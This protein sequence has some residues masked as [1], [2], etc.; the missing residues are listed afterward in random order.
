MSVSALRVVISGSVVGRLVRN[1]RGATSWEPDDEWVRGGQHPRLSYSTLVDPSRRVAGTGLPAWFENLL[2]EQESALRFRLA[3]LHAV[4][5]TDS[6]GLLRAL[7]PDLPGAVEL[8][9]DDAWRR[10]DERG[11]VGAEVD[12]TMVREERRPFQFSLAGMQLKLSMSARGVRL[13]L[14]AKSSDRHWIVKLAGRDFAELPEVEAATMAWAGASGIV[15]PANMV[16]STA[17]L[18]GLPEGWSEGSGTAYAIKRFDRRENGTRVHHEDFCQALDVLPQHKYGDTGSRRV[19]H[20]GML[21]LVANA[22]GDT[23]AEELARRVGF[24]IASGNS[25][26]HLKNWSF[27]WGAAER[28]AMS[29]AYDLVSTI[30]WR[31]PLGWGLPGG[32]RLALSLGRVKRF[33]LLD[34]AALRRHADK[35]GLS[36]ARDAIMEGIKRARDAWPSVAPQAPARMREAL[37]EHWSRVPV[38]RGAGAL[39]D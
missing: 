35:A 37:V 7:G 28:P 29:P 12:R 9:A 23:G 32:A 10:E 34:D 11:E 19:G 24:V 39:P 5:E 33:T 18:E 26:A 38:L 17:D 15:V 25:D 27:E 3:K 31:G 36:W 30:A 4:R 13:A 8:A 2:P 20:D 6:L 16:V 1:R 21:A 22:A 14:T